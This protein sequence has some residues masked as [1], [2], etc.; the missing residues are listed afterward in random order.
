VSTLWSTYLGE[1]GDHEL[2][3]VVA[4]FLAARVLAYASPSRAPSLSLEKREH[5]IAFAEATLDRDSFDPDEAR[6]LV[7]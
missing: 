7:R 2:L 1:S 3:D 4:P 5:M 6:S